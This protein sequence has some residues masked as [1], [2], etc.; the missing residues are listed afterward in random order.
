[1]AE[2]IDAL[3]EGGK[4]SPAPPLGPALA[5]LGLNIGEV[6]ADINKA[7]QDFAG[8]QVPVK[9]IVDEKTKEYDIEVG[10][11]P[12]SA[13]LLK[14]AGISKGAGEEQHI[15]PVGDISLDQAVKVAKS[16]SFP[17][18]KSGTN[19][20]LGTC[21]SMGLTCE[22]KDAREVI[23]EINEGKHDDKFQE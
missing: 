23:A 20:V 8:M 7:T 2:E 3:I 5:P 22:G 4:A 6:I 11:P 18:P 21:V 14:E 16:K 10:T 15:S 12:V 19:Q 1:M 9:V 13:L 17:N